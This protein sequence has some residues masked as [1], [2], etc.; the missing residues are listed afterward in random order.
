VEIGAEK[1]QVVAGIAEHYSPGDLAGKSVVVVANL[2][3]ATLMGLKSEGM[4]LAAEGAGGQLSLLA[5]DT[6]LPSGARIS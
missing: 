4:L 1:R 3:P 2:K 5:P 6:D